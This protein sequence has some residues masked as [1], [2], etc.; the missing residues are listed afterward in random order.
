[1]DINDVIRAVLNGS[2]A[3]QN[4]EQ[5]LP[6]GSLPPRVISHEKG[7]TASSQPM[8]SQMPSPTQPSGDVLGDILG[9][10][11]GRHPSGT[12]HTPTAPS[13]GTSSNTK[14]GMPWGDILGTMMGAGL[15]SVAANT[16]LAPIITQIAQRFNIPPRIA[17]MIVAFAIAQLVQ[18]HMQGGKGQTSRGTFQ[19]NQIMTHMGSP[20]GVSTD[21]LHNA[22]LS[23]E[24]AER[25]GL[26]A[27]TS[28]QALQ[29]AFNAL[30][31]QAQA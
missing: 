28:A 16:V 9:G 17:Q 5:S 11:L 2:P 10:V 21:L 26:D 3:N 25:T 29:F 1:M 7:G 27:N 12:S 6:Q 19:T 31:Q 15:G 20:T 18:S 23:H 30:G 13:G 4:S 22:G 24:L 14:G 8:P